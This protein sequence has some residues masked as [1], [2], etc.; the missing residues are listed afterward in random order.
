MKPQ[1]GI[2]PGRGFSSGDCMGP[3]TTPLG[4]VTTQTTCT[5]ETEFETYGYADSECASTPVFGS[6]PGV[7]TIDA[8]RRPLTH[9][10]NP[11]RASSRSS[12]RGRFRL[13]KTPNTHTHRYT[14]YKTDC[15][16][17]TEV[18]DSYSYSY[19]EDKHYKVRAAW[20]FRC[21]A[22]STRVEEGLRQ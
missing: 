10:H 5:S 17:R 16:Q 4:T 7:E 12:L 8:R 14:D 18:H 19:F 15:Y 1:V 20:M 9:T 11:R 13:V 6:C 2:N 22:S 3:T 21:C